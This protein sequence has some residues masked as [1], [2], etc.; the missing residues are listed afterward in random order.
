MFSILRNAGMANPLAS[1]PG[2]AAPGAEAAQ[3]AGTMQGLSQPAGGTA[4]QAADPNVVTGAQDSAA[5]A[6]AGP[7]LAGDDTATGA[8]D[9][10]GNLLALLNALTPAGQ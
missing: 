3:A 5:A 8:P 6:D 1:L 7:V 2:A 10:G 4:G 9:V